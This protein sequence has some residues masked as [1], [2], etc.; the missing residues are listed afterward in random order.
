MPLLKPQ[1]IFMTNTLYDARTLF[2]EADYAKEIAIL[3][4]GRDDMNL[5]RSPAYMFEQHGVIGAALFVTNAN[6]SY[7]TRMLYDKRQMNERSFS[8]FRLH[9]LKLHPYLNTSYMPVD[10]LRSF[11]LK[12]NVTIRT[13]TKFDRNLWKIHI[14]RSVLRRVITSLLSSF[15]Q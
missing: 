9:V 8:K 2:F 10:E 14:P 11:V 6:H 7:A 1:Q 13:R 3:A 12:P 4:F 5:P 15:L